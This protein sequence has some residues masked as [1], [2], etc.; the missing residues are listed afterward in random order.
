MWVHSGGNHVIQLKVLAPK[1]VLVLRLLLYFFFTNEYFWCWDHQWWIHDLVL[2]LS[3][4]IL[5]NLV[6]VFNRWFSWLFAIF[7]LIDKVPYNMVFF[8][9]WFP[10]E[11][12]F[13][14]IELVLL[15]ITIQKG[16][17]ANMLEGNLKRE[18]EWWA[19]SFV[20]LNSDFS[21]KLRHNL[22]CYC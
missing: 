1:T 17:S 9:F 16:C 12:K 8:I 20:W 4:L 18:G 2:H 6:D 5:L 21:I 3:V 14:W 19:L 7:E 11:D 15:L 13:I 22:L 10:L